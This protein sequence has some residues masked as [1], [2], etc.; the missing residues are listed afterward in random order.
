MTDN[1]AIENY[2]EIPGEENHIPASSNVIDALLARLDDPGFL[3]YSTNAMREIVH[4]A[5]ANARKVNTSAMEPIV[6]E[7]KGQQ[8]TV[9][10]IAELVDKNYWAGDVKTQYVI[11]WCTGRGPAVI[12]E[13]TLL[14]TDKAAAIQR[15]QE[16][17]LEI[18][19]LDTPYTEETANDGTDNGET[20]ESAGSNSKSEASGDDSKG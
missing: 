12:G 13:G 6:K 20:G 2:Q 16:Q 5:L 10:Y 18:P 14:F 19:Y 11:V 15:A 3:Q 8:Q 4:T 7:Y 9:A 1:P 17:A